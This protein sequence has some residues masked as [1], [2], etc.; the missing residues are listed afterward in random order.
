M[1][2]RIGLRSGR[3]RFA[4]ALLAAV[5]LLSGGCGRRGNHPRATASGKVTLGTKP[6]PGGIIVFTSVDDPNATGTA[7][8]RGDGSYDAKGVPVGKCKVSV[9]TSHLNP[10]Q[11]K[12]KAG[13]VLPASPDQY[14]QMSGDPKTGKQYVPIPAKYESGDGGLEFE[15][16]EGANTYDI[17]LAEK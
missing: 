7:Y 11:P 1:S 10:V 17:P 13:E 16:K 8:V 15:V 4:L 2:P 5:V 6:L 12:P 9:K 3:V 14:V